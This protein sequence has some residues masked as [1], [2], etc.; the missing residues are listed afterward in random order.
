MNN[1]A[2]VCHEVSKTTSSSLAFIHPSIALQQ[3]SRI[4]CLLQHQLISIGWNSM[5][6]VLVLVCVVLVTA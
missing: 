3:H 4:W 2:T 5:E 6:L 1:E